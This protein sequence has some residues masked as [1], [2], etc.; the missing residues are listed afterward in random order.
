M[1]RRLI[2]WSVG[3]PLIV[4]LAAVALAAIGVYAFVRVNVEAYPDPAPAIIEVIALYPG[5][6][7]E[8][9][10]RRVTIPLET[11]LAG[12]PG[13]TYT[14]SKSLAGLSHLRNQFEYGIDFYKARQEVINRLQNLQ[15]GQDIPFGVNPQISPMTPTGELYRYTIANPRDELGRELPVYTLNDLKAVQDWTLERQFRRVPRIIDVVSFGGSIKRYEIHPDPNR[16]RRHGITLQQLQNAVANSNSNV[17]GDY[18]V[19]GQTAQ[20]VRGVGLIGGGLDPMH[21]KE[22]LAVQESAPIG[23]AVRAASYL[24]REDERR[25]REIREIVIASINNVPVR[26]E[27]VVDGG[28]LMS[29]GEPVGSQGVV[30]GTQTRL[31]RFS[32]S[33]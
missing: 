11:V 1:V 23:A 30:V 21:A 18:L 26:V 19:A 15:P 6:S 8:E 12:M 20:S 9:V 28:P 4:V 10:E 13:L 16:M 31:G 2:E 32:V 5:A 33:R 25:I 7:A 3:N 29:L 27:D 24:R 14:R 17:G 22:V